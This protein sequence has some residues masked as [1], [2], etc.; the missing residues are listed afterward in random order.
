[1]DSQAEDC[2]RARRLVMRCFGLL[3]QDIEQAAAGAV[4]IE[5]CEAL[6]GKDSHVTS[7]VK[8]TQLL[9]KLVPLERALVEDTP[10]EPEEEYAPDEEDWQTLEWYMKRRGEG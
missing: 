8:L 10:E 9:V 4:P 3:E 6:W 5:P 1:M 2:I 7:L